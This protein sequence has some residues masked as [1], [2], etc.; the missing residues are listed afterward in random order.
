LQA[1]YFSGDIIMQSDDWRPLYH[2]SE[3]AELPQIGSG[4]LKLSGL[5][6]EILDGWRFSDSPESDWFQKMLNLRTLL[7]EI[8]ILES[9]NL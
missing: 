2:F 6:V 5:D 4:W 1:H 8:D 3:A 9:T 7:Y